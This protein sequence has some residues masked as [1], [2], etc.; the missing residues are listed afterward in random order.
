MR[1]TLTIVGLV[2]ACGVEDFDQDGVPRSEDCNDNDPSQARP[3][4]LHLDGDRDGYGGDEVRVGCQGNAW[5]VA[6]QLDCNDNDPLVNPDVPEQACDGRDNDCDAS[7]VDGPASSEGRTWPTVQQAVNAARFGSVVEICA[8]VVEESISVNRR[9]RLQGQGA[10]RTVLQGSGD[11][12]VV[13]LDADAELSGLTIAGGDAPRG[14]GV[15]VSDLVAAPVVLVDV[16]VRDNRGDEGGGIWSS[17][18]S[19][20]LV[21]VSL[22]GNRATSG[23]AIYAAPDPDQELRLQRVTLTGNQA[24]E[25]GAIYLSGSMRADETTLV[26]NRATR[27][28]ALWFD[29]VVASSTQSL[30]FVENGAVSGAGAYGSGE[31][32]G[33]VFERNLGDE[34]G[35]ITT[36]GPLTLIEVSVV[37]NRAE[38]GDGGGVLATAPMTVQ[39]GT[40]SSNEA[41]GLGGAIS[42]TDRLTVVGTA[43]DENRARSGGGVASSGFTRLD[44]AR[45]VDNVAEANGGAVFATCSSSDLEIDATAILASRAVRGAALWMG[46]RRGRVSNTRI[47][48]NAGTGPVVEVALDAC[49]ASRLDVGAEMT[50]A[51]NS[52]QDIGVGLG[53]TT[54]PEQ[55]FRCEL[56]GQGA[57]CPTALP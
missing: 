10:E 38:G 22:S 57:A 48:S 3:L 50:W 39:G 16:T 45:F 4:P 15:W 12:P 20:E 41:S 11:G 40:M 9:V 55:P 56:L 36:T 54:A 19:L 37:A 26:G 18:A 42:A 51:D 43:F 28:G 31:I 34:G 17:G 29:G 52:P 23:G 5:L 30:A 24:N 46:G 7:T 53:G 8:S 32:R 49:E 13:R 2:A 33:A 44:G 25:G 21:D 1:H 27:G 6:N 14:G 47:E 35:A